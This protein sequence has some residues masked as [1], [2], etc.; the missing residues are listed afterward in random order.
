VW[1]VDPPVVLDPRRHGREASW[2]RAG[3]MDGSESARTGIT[4]GRREGAATPNPRAIA[5]LSFFSLC[6]IWGNDDGAGVS[7]RTGVVEICANREG[8]II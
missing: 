5:R 2:R 3:R 1:M 6:G 8:P 4:G 7:A